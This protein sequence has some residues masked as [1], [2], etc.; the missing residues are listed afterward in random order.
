VVVFLDFDLELLAPRFRASEEAMALLGRAGR[1]V[2]GRDEAG[3]GRRIVVQT[4]LPD[5][6]VLD[7]AVHGDPARLALVEAARRAALRLPPE[8]ALARVSGPGG[9]KLAGEL[10]RTGPDVEVVG[11]AGDRWLVRAA[12]HRT[13]C[14]ALASAPRPSER[15]RVEVDPLRA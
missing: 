3:G 15:V 10:R 6:E 2:G 5:H 11:P 9:A 12:D 4:R 14:D 7:A 13:L 8:T 1:L